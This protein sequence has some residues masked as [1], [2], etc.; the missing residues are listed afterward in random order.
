MPST[1]AKTERSVRLRTW[2]LG[3][4]VLL[5]V[6]RFGPVSFSTAMFTAGTQNTNTIGAAADWTPP[7]VILTDPGDAIRGT[8][9][10]SATA[11]DGE[12]GVKN[13]VIAWAP[14]GTTTF[15]TICTDTSS[16]YSCSFNT[17]GLSDQEID[18]RATATDNSNYT[19]TDLIEAVYVDNTLPTV[20]LNTI[21]SPMTG[22]VTIS[23][24][25]TDAGSG[26]DN[27]VIQRSSAGLNTWTTICTDI[28]SPYSC[29]FDTT[30]VSDGLYDFRAIATDEAGN[31]RTSTTV[32][33]RVVSN[34]AS[35]TSVND[36]G[37][38]LRGTVTITANGNATLGINN[39]KIQRAPNGTTTWTDIC[40]DSTSP[41]SCSWDTT[42]VADGLYIFRSVMTDSVGQVTTSA[43]VGPSQVDNTV[44]R[45]Y[46]VQA[47]N[48]T[49]TGK[50]A[51][52][53]TLAVTYS[54][55]MNLTTIMSG[56]T[57]TS[58]NVVIRLRDG[59]LLGLTS[60]QDTVD[61]FTTSGLTTQVNLGSVNLK[62][63]FVKAN[64]IVT[65]N[66]TMVASTVTVNGVSATKV[67]L[68]VGTILTNSTQ[69]RTASSTA[70]QMLWTPSATA[71]DTVGNA[72]STA[73][74]T[75]L[76][77]NDR[78]F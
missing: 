65:M 53:D 12:T 43:T 62:G 6:L 69:L 49:T 55:A 41:Y 13:V 60:T 11:T 50:I 46:D 1:H 9:T 32:T 29:S 21:A 28:D 76:G 18:I 51:A 38:Y 47:T 72:C 48:V 7:T 40:T 64:K 36:P 59:A 15:T 37:A 8:V 35:S 77:T 42:T 30:T 14:T 39:I 61:V 52:N 24:T 33:N 74:V 71:K 10:L 20:S 63:N 26:V 23:A 78:D 57:G 73:V 19:D 2:G 58:T 5:A 75:E 22:V 27:V 66:A 25:A 68:T 4:L 34:I 70:V 31:A 56:W 44:V 45:G 3:F 16:P 54:R 67:T 17:T